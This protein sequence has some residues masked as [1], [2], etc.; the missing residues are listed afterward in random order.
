MSALDT[1]DVRPWP[2]VEAERLRDALKGKD[3]DRP[4]LFE[5]G[6]GP[7][8]LPHIGTFS[9]VARTTFVRRGFQHLTG[10]PTR[11]VAFSDDMDGLRKVPLNIPHPE[12]V[13][14]HLGKPLSSIPDPFG[15]DSSYSAHMN[16]R[17]REFL[18][19]YG[20]AHDFLSATQQYQS[21]AFDAGLLRVLERV[22]AVKDVVVPTLGGGGREKKDDWSPFFPICPACGRVYTT[23][24]T[25]YHPSRGEISFVCDGE[26]GEFRGCG[27][28]GDLPVSGGGVKVGWK[29]DW[30][31]RWFTLGVDY[32]M[33]GK[34]LIESA[35]LSA[36]IVRVLGGQ[37][38]LG[39]VYEMFL[40]E[41]GQKISKSVGK[42]ITVDSWLEYTLPGSLYGYL[43]QNP[44]KA[45]K[46]TYEAIPKATDEHL[47]LL[48]QMPSLQGEARLGNP[49]WFF[50][51]GPPPPY[52]SRVDWSLCRNLVACLGTADEGVVMA[53]LRR[54]DPSVMEPENAAVVQQLVRGAIAYDRDFEAPGRVYRRPSE[55]EAGWILGLTDLL[56]AADSHDA[57]LFQ[58]LAFE[59]ARRQGVEARELFLVIYQGLLGQSRGPRLGSLVLTLGKDEAIERLRRLAAWAYEQPPPAS[60]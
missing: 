28:G 17:L 21:G 13:R 60:A 58:S 51:E 56:S 25:A 57:D 8:G 47:E 18:N 1:L 22:E 5:T 27:H 55:Q 11:L 12:T 43:Y 26:Y 37:P 9:E 42:G 2:L 6:F 30:A 49:T 59:A 39:Y 40:D 10:R 31:L 32:E 50:Q 35:E 3:P 7:S 44:R 34:D 19:G 24:V 52:H 16:R 38:P 33:Y 41:S 46:L 48:R 45:R 20:L 53:Y 29:V 54:Y 14:P 36:R 4:V 23:R 15:T